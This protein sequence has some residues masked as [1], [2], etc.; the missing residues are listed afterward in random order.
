MKHHIRQTEAFRWEGVDLLNYKE[1][2]GTH[3]KS[4]TR[5]VLAGCNDDFPVELR[6]FEVAPGGY[7]TFERHEHIHIVLIGR[8][9]GQCLVVDTVHDLGP[10]DVVHIPPMTWHQFHATGSGPLGFFCLV[11]CERDRPQRPNDE[12]LKTLR[13]NPVIANFIRI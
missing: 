1:E 7:S 11:K 6:Y 13:S 12:D 5:Q 10:M 8:G 9:T 2:G 4:I 3:F